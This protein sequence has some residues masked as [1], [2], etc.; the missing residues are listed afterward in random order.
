MSACFGQSV[1]RGS[2]RL[3]RGAEVLGLEGTP[4]DLLSGLVEPLAPALGGADLAQEG[5]SLGDFLG[6]LGLRGGRRDVHLVSRYSVL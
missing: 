2:D 4:Q 1:G 6:F 5:G 3:D